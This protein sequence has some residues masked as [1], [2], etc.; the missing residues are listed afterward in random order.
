M[1]SSDMIEHV[2]FWEFVMWLLFFYIYLGLCIGLFGLVKELIFN[3]FDMQQVLD[4][5]EE[6]LKRKLCRSK[7]EKE[8]DRHCSSQEYRKLVNKRDSLKNECDN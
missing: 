1:G 2:G 4:L 6:N 3:M 5:E 8:F 7:E